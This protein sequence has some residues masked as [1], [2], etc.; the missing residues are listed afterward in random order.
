[1]QATQASKPNDPSFERAVHR[2]LTLEL[3]GGV[4]VRRERVV[5]ATHDEPLEARWPRLKAALQGTRRRTL[6]REVELHRDRI[7]HGTRGY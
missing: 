2:G 7:A 6:Q 1:M 5:R 4:A 3:S